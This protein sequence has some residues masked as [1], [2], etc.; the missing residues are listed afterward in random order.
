M[1][2]TKSILPN[3]PKEQGRTAQASLKAMNAAQKKAEQLGNSLTM[4]GLLSSSSNKASSTSSTSSSFVDVTG[5][6][7]MSSSAQ[8]LHKQNTANRGP[9]KAGRRG[10]KGIAGQGSSDKPFGENTAVDWVPDPNEPTYCLCNQVSYGEMVGCDNPSCP[11]EWFHYG[12]VG[13]TD[14][15]KGKWY[16]PDCS[17]VIKKRRVR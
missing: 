13:L 16:C 12:C 7:Y 5:N 1:L 2:P 8:N 11:I 17:A 4:S 10:Q 15:P 14:A 3:N 6:S 9:Q